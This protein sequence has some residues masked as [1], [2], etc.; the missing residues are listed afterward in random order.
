L[1]EI[2]ES[3]PEAADTASEVADPEIAVGPPKPVVDYE[4]VERL[5]APLKKQEALY[6]KLRNKVGILRTY[7]RQAKI[8]FE[9]GV[10]EEALAL[11]DKIETLSV[12]LRRKDVLEEMYDKKLS[13]LKDLGRHAEADA[14]LEKQQELTGQPK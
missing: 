8:L 10:L 11:Y 9:N 2:A 3:A 13:I 6:T 4:R 1:L 7:G 5:M 12:E 14:V